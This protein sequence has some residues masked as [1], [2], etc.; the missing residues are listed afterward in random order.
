MPS[1]REGHPN[2]AM[3]ALAC[4]RPLVASQAGALTELVTASRGLSVPSA[5]GA[6]LSDA[7]AAALTRRWDHA[8]IAASVREESWSRAAALTSAPQPPSSIWAR[9]VRRMQKSAN[10]LRAF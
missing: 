7:L 1:R 3:E 4:G 2:A 10:S 8:A 9:P 5:G 6:A